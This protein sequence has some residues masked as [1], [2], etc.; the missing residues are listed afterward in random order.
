[1]EGMQHVARQQQSW[2]TDIDP[3]G[4]QQIKAGIN[5]SCRGLCGRPSKD[6]NQHAQDQHI[7]T[8]ATAHCLQGDST[9]MCQ[10]AYEQI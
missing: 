4:P 9:S 5:N 8:G 10:N 3:D 6:T 1:M 2:A 7:A